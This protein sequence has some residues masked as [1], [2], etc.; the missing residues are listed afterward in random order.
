M[1]KAVEK[2]LYPY[3]LF[4]KCC[5]ISVTLKET[6]AKVKHEDPKANMVLPDNYICRWLPGN[7]WGTISLPWRQNSTY[8]IRNLN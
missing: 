2:E 6:K 5:E 7:N 1:L 4:I 3:F 8:G